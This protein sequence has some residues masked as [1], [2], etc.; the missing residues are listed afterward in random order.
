MNAFRALAGVTLAGLCALVAAG[1]GGDD[2]PSDAVAKVGDT[3]VTRQQ[4]DRWYENAA[5]SQAQQGGPAVAPDPPNYTKCVAALESQQP[6]GTPAQDSALKKQCKTSYDQLKQQVMQFLIQSEWVQQEAERQGVTVKDAEV[7][8]LFE[9][10]KKQAFPKEA[11]YRKF[12]KTSGATEADILFRVKL[13]ALQGKLAEKVQKDQSE[14][15]DEDVED[16]FNEN[17]DRFTQPEQRDLSIVL[18]KDKAK[19]AQAKKEL[20]DGASFKEVSKKYSVDQASKAQGGKLP[21]VTRGRQDKAFDEAIF[22]AE[23]GDLQGPVK[24]QFGWYVFEVD[25]ITP[26]KEQ[27]LDEAKQSIRGLLK[28]ENQSKSLQSFID[29]FRERYRGETACR[30]DFVVPECSNAPE[31]ETNTGPASGG[32]PGGTPQQAPPPQAA[33]QGAAP[34]QAP[35]STPAP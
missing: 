18:T 32:A 35:Q 25:K 34:Q 17:K 23:K 9:G 28:Q 4:F 21:G 16:Y 22:G 14:I 2:V 12:L 10:Q 8:R 29:D 24:T 3:V 7:R 11:A 20:E 26:A 33:P 6:K 1:C 13:D 31:P 15:T 5:K 19:A 27:T 30:E